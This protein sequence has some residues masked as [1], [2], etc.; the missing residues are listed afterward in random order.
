MTKETIDALELHLRVKEDLKEIL[1]LKEIAFKIFRKHHCPLNE[2]NSILEDGWN[3]LLNWNDEEHYGYLEIQDW[4]IIDNAFNDVC[5]AIINRTEFV[6]ILS[7][8]RNG[9]EKYIQFLE[10]KIKETSEII[11][12]AYDDFI[13]INE[14]EFDFILKSPKVRDI[15]I[16]FLLT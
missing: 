12:K 14:G 9:V 8:S 2:M 15:F 7:E 6:S 10:A 13:A 11:E 16:K 3:A 1:K 5:T 4:R